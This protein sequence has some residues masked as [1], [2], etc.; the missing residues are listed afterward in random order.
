LVTAEDVMEYD[1]DDN[2]VGARGR[3]SYGER[4]IHSEIYKARTDVHAVVH[5]HSPSVIPFSISSVSLKPISHMAGFL[6]GSGVRNPRGWKR[7]RH[8]DRKQALGAALAKKLGNG[9]AALAGHTS[10]LIP[11]G[12]VAAAGLI[13]LLLVASTGV[14]AGAAVDAFI[15]GSV[16]SPCA[17]AAS[18][19]RRVVSVLVGIGFVLANRANL[20]NVGG[21][22]QIAVGGIA[23]TAV[24]L[25]GGVANLPLALPILVPMLAAVAAGALW[26]ALAGIFKVEARY[27]KVTVSQM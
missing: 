17:I 25:Y 8:V 15:G 13:S 20:T 6:I 4:F 16:G 26:G 18:I 14:S 24:A 12:A 10:I 27:R 1:F 19:N 2:A 9:T 21:E 22:G 23:A 11:I 3:F 7:D 5:S